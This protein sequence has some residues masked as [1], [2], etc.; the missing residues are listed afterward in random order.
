MVVAEEDLRNE[1]EEW[2]SC[3]LPRCQRGVVVG[4]L[5]GGKDKGGGVS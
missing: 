1:L 3:T 2:K 4:G 5:K